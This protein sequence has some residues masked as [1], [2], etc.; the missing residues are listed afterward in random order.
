MRVEYDGTGYCGFQHQV[1]PDRPTI[2]SELEKALER[3]Y[4]RFIRVRGASRTDAGVHA[5]GQVVDFIHTGRIPIERIPAAMNSLLPPDIAVTGAL[6]APASFDPRHDAVKKTYRY[7]VHNSPH[8]TA[9][10]R[11]FRWHVPQPLDIDAMAEAARHLV[12][13]LDFAAFKGARGSAKTTVRTMHRIDVF[14]EG[15]CVHLVFEADGFLYN[16]ARAMAGTLIEVGLGRRAPEKMPE[17]IAGGNRSAAGPTAPP[18]GLCLMEIVYPD[19]RF[20]S[21]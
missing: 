18:Q 19:L 16:M 1:R 12:G 15:P 7:S 21:S 3:L 8:P 2:Q 13:R 6:E 20:P 10:W 4:G 14:R 9:L 5:L 11:R 17:V